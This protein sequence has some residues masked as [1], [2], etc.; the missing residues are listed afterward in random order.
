MPIKNICQCD[1]PPG[2][3]TVCE[4]HQ[5]AVCVVSNGV[6]DKQCIDPPV[7]ASDEALCNWAISVITNV[8]RHP[9]DVIS[10]DELQILK[11]GHYYVGGESIKFNL[12]TSIR[13]ALAQINQK[14]QQGTFSV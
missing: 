7:T 2:G 11:G 8:S 10:P 4:P 5:L 6:A 12:P 1:L 9:N 3:Q 14:G 13:T